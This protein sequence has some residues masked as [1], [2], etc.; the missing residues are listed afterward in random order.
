MRTDDRNDSVHDLRIEGGIA[1]NEISSSIELCDLVGKVVCRSLG[2]NNC[3]QQ[4][5]ERA[6]MGEYFEVWYG[7][8]IGHLASVYAA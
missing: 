2:H 1:E 3:A 8:D 5:Y 6:W 7:R 4:L